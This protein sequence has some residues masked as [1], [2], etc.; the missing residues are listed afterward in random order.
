MRGRAGVHG[1][2]GEGSA[3]LGKGNESAGPGIH[4]CE[5]SGV[6]G[7]WGLDTGAASKPVRGRL[8]SE[9]DGQ[10]TQPSRRV[11]PGSVGGGRGGRC[12]LLPQP[13]LPPPGGTPPIPGASP[14]LPAPPSCWGCPHAW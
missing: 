11:R 6:W 5:G 8:V 14:P 3:I 9:K 12:W 13:L 10:E 1:W 4:P 2:A 7:G